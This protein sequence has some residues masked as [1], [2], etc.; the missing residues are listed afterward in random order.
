MNGLEIIVYSQLPQLMRVIFSTWDSV[1][2]CGVPKLAHTTR[3]L[4]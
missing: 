1:Q 3:G 4:E 2:A